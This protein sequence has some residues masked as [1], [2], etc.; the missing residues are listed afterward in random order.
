MGSVAK[1]GVVRTTTWK[2]AH[3]KAHL[4][5]M[6]SSAGEVMDYHTGG[7]TG[8]N[9]QGSFA[10]NSSGAQY[11]TTNVGSDVGDA[12]SAGATGY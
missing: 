7:V 4:S 10:G 9:S 2:P 3:A 1:H 8:Q 12:D 6:V 11:S 5:K